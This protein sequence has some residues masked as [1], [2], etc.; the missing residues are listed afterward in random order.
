LA[1]FFGAAF[2]FAGAFLVAAITSPPFSQKVPVQR[3]PPNIL[4]DLQLNLLIL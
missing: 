3:T 1:V 4:W 2:F